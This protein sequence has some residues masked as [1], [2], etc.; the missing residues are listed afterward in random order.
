MSP[1][2]TVTAVDREGNI[3]QRFANYADPVT[4][5]KASGQYPTVN[6]SALYRTGDA[7]LMTT[8]ARLTAKSCLVM[9]RAGIFE[10]VDFAQ[11]L[12]RANYFGY[13]IYH[14]NL[15][16]LVGGFAD[17]SQVVIRM[18]A[19]SSTQ[20]A[21]STGT[22][23]YHLIRTGRLG[24]LT[25]E[26]TD[27]GHAYNGYTLYQGAQPVDGKSAFDN[28]LITGIPGTDHSPPGETFAINVYDT[29]GTSTAHIKIGGPNLEVSGIRTS[30]GALVGASPI[31]WNSCTWLD[32]LGGNFHDT[33]TSMPTFWKSSDCTTTDMTSRRCGSSTGVRFG[34]GINHEE[35]T[36]I[37]H[38]RPKLYIVNGAIVTQHMSVASQLT[39]C[40]VTV[41]D[42]T[43]DHP[44][45]VGGNQ[46]T[47]AIWANYGTGEKVTGTLISVVDAAGAPI[48]T[49]IYT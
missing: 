37:R 42:P 30:D 6:Y 27:Q 28:L 4:T 24:N 18:R 49:K 9:D 48:P 40:Q 1:T 22:N 41:T 13:G 14:P 34:C 44:A 25:V 5:V 3:A 17:R 8:I 31:G 7:T 2:V 23:N 32:L 15:A 45:Y 11:A 47:I 36:R 38:T 29:H 21:P 10:C 20:V 43:F 46:F 39:D 33:Y 19:H 16:E 26:G 35:S 12:D